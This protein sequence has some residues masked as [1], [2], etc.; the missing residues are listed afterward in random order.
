M[1]TQLR[2]GI[3][4]ANDIYKKLLLE[5][6]I[7]WYF[8]FSEQILGLWEEEGKDEPLQMLCLESRTTSISC[9]LSQNWMFW[10]WWPRRTSSKPTQS[11]L[12]S[13]SGSVGKL[14]TVLSATYSWWAADSLTSDQFQFKSVL[15]YRVGSGSFYTRKLFACLSVLKALFTFHMRW[16]DAGHSHTELC[17]EATHTHEISFSHISSCHVAQPVPLAR[18]ALSWLLPFTQL[19]S[20]RSPLAIWS[21]TQP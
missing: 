19:S 3:M 4:W 9:F 11:S 20:D 6:N 5:V 15:V 17:V 21:R 1:F 13:T 12:Q 18:P 16:A 7:S 2:E 14:Q 8:Y 10:E